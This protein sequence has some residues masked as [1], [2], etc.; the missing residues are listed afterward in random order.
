MRILL[1]TPDPSL[2]AFVRRSLMRFRFDWVPVANG[3][4]AFQK[5]VGSRFDLILL[6]FDL[7]RMKA[8]EVLRRLSSLENFK[9][10]SVSDN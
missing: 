1:A 2:A 7:P 6:E 4:D 5:A 9:I 10:I 3:L 8:G